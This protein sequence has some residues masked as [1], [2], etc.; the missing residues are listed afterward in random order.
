VVLVSWPNYKVEAGPF[1]AGEFEKLQTVLTGL[2]E[3]C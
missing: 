2:G 3:I 1:A